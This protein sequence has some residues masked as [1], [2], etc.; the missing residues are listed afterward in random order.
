MTI[1]D[2]K[3]EVENWGKKKKK[4]LM[5]VGY[6]CWEIKLNYK[7]QDKKNEVKIEQ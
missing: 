5:L 3:N 6:G 2:Q 4:N 1:K 7:K